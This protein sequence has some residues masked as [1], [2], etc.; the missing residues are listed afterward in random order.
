MEGADVYE[1]GITI[2][3]SSKTALEIVLAD[4]GG[5]V[6]G[7]VLTRRTGF[8]ISIDV[9]GGNGLAYMVIEFDQFGAEERV[10]GI[11]AV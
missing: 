11:V 9:G 7:A 5:Q 1:K 10:F 3:D 6:D 8:H 2:A 4:E